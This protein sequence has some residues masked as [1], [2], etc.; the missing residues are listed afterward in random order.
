M[1]TQWIKAGYTDETLPALNERVLVA[2]YRKWGENF[3]QEGRRV[4]REGMGGW[5]WID[6]TGIPI[7]HVTHWQRVVAPDE[8]TP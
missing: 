5:W 4:R 2:G 8:T 1:S 3:W 7:Y 6:D